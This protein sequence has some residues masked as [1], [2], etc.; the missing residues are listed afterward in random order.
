MNQAAFVGISA[1]P[2]N[3]F[4][5]PQASGRA[6]AGLAERRVLITGAA[7]PLGQLLGRRLARECQVYG[8]DV[9][10]PPTAGFSVTLLDARDPRLMVLMREQGITHVVHLASVVKPTG[11][12]DQDYDID[13]NGARNVLQ[14]C[15]VSGVRHFT[16]VSSTAAYGFH[17]DNPAECDEADTLR[18]DTA[19]AHADRTRQVEE[20]LADFRA[21]HPQLQQLVFR[22]ATILGAQVESLTAELLQGRHLVAVSGTSAPFSFVWE[23]D[24]VEAMMQGLQKDATGIFNMSGDGTVTIDEIGKILGKPVLRLPGILLAGILYFRQFCCLADHG[25]ERV[26]M[27]RYRPVPSNRRLKEEFGFTP[28]KSS[29]E[30]FRSFASRAMGVELPA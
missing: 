2:S 24:M 22:P 18:G 27:L 11:D 5:E 30:A 28:Q 15:V 13:V 9:H 19:L 14:A 4:P 23:E 3:S 29:L 25:A 21:F 7:S 26:K 12:R 6:W 1:K 17:A 10:L 16:L 8:V 20:L